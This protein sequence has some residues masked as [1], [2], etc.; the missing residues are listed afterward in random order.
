[1]GADAQNR[2]HEGCTGLV[3]TQPDEPRRLAAR[4]VQGKVVGVVGAAKVLQALVPSLAP[5]GQSDRL[6]LLRI[7]LLLLL[8]AGVYFLF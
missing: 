4:L 5:I 6:A 1:M 3:Y 2:V 7:L 8:L